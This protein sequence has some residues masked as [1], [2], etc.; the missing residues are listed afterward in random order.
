MLNV[1][2]NGTNIFD[3]LEGNTQ[4]IIDFFVSYYGE[5]HRERITKRLNNTTLIFTSRNLFG[6]NPLIENV[7]HFYSQK[8][9]FI[10]NKIFSEL[11]QYTP[12][13]PSNFNTPG[14]AYLVKCAI[15]ENNIDVLMYDKI[16]DLIEMFGLE[17]PDCP[18]VDYNHKTIDEWLA[19]DVNRDRVLRCVNYILRICKYKYGDIISQVLQEKQLAISQLKTYDNQI[20]I[21][22]NTTSNICKILVGKYLLKKCPKM[23]K[24]TADEF[25]DDVDIFMSIMQLGVENFINKDDFLR[26]ESLILIELFKHMGFN[27]GNDISKYQSNY[28]LL[29][30][31]FDNELCEQVNSYSKKSVVEMC[32]NNPYFQDVLQTIQGL[33]IKGG[34]LEIAYSALQFVQNVSTQ[35]AVMLQYIDSKTDELKFVCLFPDAVSVCD[36][37]IFHELN[38]VIESDLVKSAEDGFVAKCGFEIFERKYLNEDFCFENL[39]AGKKVKGEETSR[40]KRESEIF[41]EI[42]ND[43]FALQMYKKVREKGKVYAFGDMRLSAYMSCY[44]FLKGFVVKYEKQIIDC[45]LSKDPKAFEKLIGK[46]NMEL[47]SIS[48]D[49]L[50]NYYENYNT[51]YCQAIDEI[52]KKTN[53]PSNEV[54]ARF[55]EYINLKIEWSKPAEMF[56]S[57]VKTISQTFD[58]IDQSL[59]Q[60]NNSATEKIARTFKKLKILPTPQKR[61]DDNGDQK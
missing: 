2:V 37:A 42:I 33:N 43:Y 59:Q 53:I 3:P 1:T 14:D 38:H 35:G 31:I 17:R 8:E 41:N 9:N 5:E 55:N 6:E 51:Y 25:S 7:K 23:Q 18:L 36:Y 47:L 4:E 54:T 46:D 28:K 15:E 50:F 10:Y 58:K 21:A 32:K 20:D 34:N 45:R 60:S 30:V 56:V 49:F 11:V 19:I 57:T 29:S 13:F 16:T 52:S 27:L 39:L 40:P 48:F 26:T 22:V 24:L 44:D 12:K 61:P